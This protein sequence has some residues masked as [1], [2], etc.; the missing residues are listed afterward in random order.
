MHNDN[1]WLCAVGYTVVFT[2][3]AWV[4]IYLTTGHIGALPESVASIWR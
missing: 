4:V 3:L 2:A 1:P